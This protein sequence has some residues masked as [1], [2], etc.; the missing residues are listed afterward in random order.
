MFVGVDAICWFDKLKAEEHNEMILEK[1]KTLQEIERAWER[2]LWLK[3]I[4]YGLGA[5]PSDSEC[6]QD[7]KY[8][9]SEAKR[10]SLLL[11]LNKLVAKS[12]SWY[13]LKLR[14]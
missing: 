8:L 12:C 7:M 2:V 13:I 3:S 14:A 4:V 5:V 9:R 11:R 10:L 1:F 6:Y